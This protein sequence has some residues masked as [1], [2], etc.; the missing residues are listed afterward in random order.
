MISMNTDYANKTQRES[1]ARQTLES[2][3]KT[4]EARLEYAADE[5]EKERIK[6]QLQQIEV[7]VCTLTV[8]LAA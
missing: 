6:Q 8:S 7:S 5:A 3:K 2:F 1:L 4:Q